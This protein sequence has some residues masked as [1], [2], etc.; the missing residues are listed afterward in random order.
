MPRG[1]F[2]GEL[3]QMLLLAVARLGEEAYGMAIR[4][5]IERRTATEVAIASVYAAL[6]RLGRQGYVRSWV[7]SPTPERGG[8]AKR[9]FGL[10]PAGARALH[11]ARAA[12]DNLWD[13]LELDAE[14]RTG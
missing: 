4:E 5:E 12:L 11:R 13:N 8:R 3:E 14:G 7:G 1:E 2:L 10:E 9:F 6:D